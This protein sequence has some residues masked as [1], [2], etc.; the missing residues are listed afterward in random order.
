MTKTNIA[1]IFTM[2]VKRILIAAGIL[3]FIDALIMTFMTNFNAGIIITAL[4]AAALVIVGVYFEKILRIKWLISCIAVVTLLLIVEITFIAVYG[5]NDNAD[6]KEDAVIVLGAGIK[7]EEVSGQLA[8]RLDKAVE[9]CNKNPD[10]VIVVSG[11]QGA[12]ELISEALAMERYLISKGIS[13][14]RIIKEEE[15]VS[16]YT[17]F[18]NSKKILD[19]YFENDY[20]AVFITGGYHIFRASQISQSVGL[21]CTHCHSEIDWYS[22][23]VSYLRE[24]AAV[25]KF[26][27]TGK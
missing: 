16:T 7:G 20:N 25:V 21:D 3:L 24:C 4:V 11:G 6:Y 5:R 12:D 15:S 22:A 10:A 27:V 9:Y 18:V 26:L 8:Y 23:P 1:K 2:T 14:D 19:E 17:N 13:A